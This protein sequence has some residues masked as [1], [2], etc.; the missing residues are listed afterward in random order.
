MTKM[1]TTVV[2]AL[3]LKVKTELMMATVKVQTCCTKLKMEKNTRK[4]STK[5]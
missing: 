4:Q 1:F 5:E 3:A 2:T